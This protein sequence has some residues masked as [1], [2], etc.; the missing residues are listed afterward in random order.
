MAYHESLTPADAE[1]VVG[2]L[3]LPLAPAYPAEGLALV[4]RANCCGKTVP[5]PTAGVPPLD[6]SEWPVDSYE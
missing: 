5:T 1:A 4:G 6:E 2:R 3:K